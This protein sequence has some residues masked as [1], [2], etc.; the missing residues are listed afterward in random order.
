VSVLS[1][2]VRG[3]FGFWYSF[4]IGED[5]VGAAGVVVL[6]GGTWVLVHVGI[7]AYWFGPAVIGTTAVVLVA[8]GLRRSAPG[9]PP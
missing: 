9:P 5:W 6:I 3:F 8:R 2:V 1:K 7:L 4:V